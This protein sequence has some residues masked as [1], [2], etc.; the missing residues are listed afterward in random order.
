MAVTPDPIFQFIRPASQGD[1]GAMRKVF[2]L[3]YSELFAIARNIRF[4]FHG[5]DTLNTT[6]IIHEAYLKLSSNE[7][8]WESKAHFYAV[9][10]K[11]MRQVMLNAARNKQREK[12]GGGAVTS[13][14]D[15]VENQLVLSPAAS[16]KLIDFDALLK[17]L[18][19]KDTLY[20]RIVECR[21]FS[22][23]SIEE[24]AD[25][26][27]VSPATVK[28]KWQMARAWL[29]VHLPRYGVS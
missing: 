9:A 8:Q 11:A 24:T 23:L 18:E 7:G 17:Q 29:F 19:E 15:E 13:S 28:R 12:R 10:A 6:A 2:P 22:G 26:L 3:I 25:V 21:F 20:G 16:E 1:A 27:Q 5:I 4:N 14:L